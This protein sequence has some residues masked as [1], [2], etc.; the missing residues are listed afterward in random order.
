MLSFLL[1]KYSEMG[2]LD[3]MAVLFLVFEETP[4]SFSIPTNRKKHSLISTSAPKL[5]SCLFDNTHDNK[6]KVISH[7][8]FDLH[9]P[10]DE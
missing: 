9:F 8:G 2:L 7:S 6:C 10:D 3:H 4:Y 1:D 5:I